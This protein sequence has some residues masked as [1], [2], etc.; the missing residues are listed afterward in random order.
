MPSGTDQVRSAVSSLVARCPTFEAA[1]TT[2][3]YLC[4]QGVPS[5]AL[6]VVVDGGASYSELMPSHRYY[7]TS[8]RRN[9]QRSRKLLATGADAQGAAD[10]LNAVPCVGQLP[11]ESLHPSHGVVRTSRWSR[12]AR[13]HSG[14]T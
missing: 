12:W 13:P 8:D 4:S 14:K 9:A 5:Q 11:S 3:E 2:A 1:S 6:S 7:V 10:G